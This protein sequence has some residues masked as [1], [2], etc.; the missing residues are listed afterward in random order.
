MPFILFLDRAT[1]RCFLQNAFVGVLTSVGFVY[2]S[3]D[4]SDDYSGLVDAVLEDAVKGGPAQDQTVACINYVAWLQPIGT[5][6]DG[7]RLELCV[8]VA[9][10]HYFLACPG[11]EFW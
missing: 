5:R 11:F 4:G 7:K 9:V 10:Y 2:I 1:A 6:T 3:L 8:K